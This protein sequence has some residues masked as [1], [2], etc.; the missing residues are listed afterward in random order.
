MKGSFNE[1][2]IEVYNILSSMDASS[3]AIETIINMLEDKV[4]LTKNPL[5][6]QNKNN[7]IEI[8]MKLLD[9]KDWRKRA[10]LSAK[11]I[12]MSLE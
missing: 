8:K 12:S 7:E 3:D 10:S 5:F 9:G 4:A 2:Q 6:I 1:K 11:L